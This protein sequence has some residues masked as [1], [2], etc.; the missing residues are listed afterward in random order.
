VLSIVTEVGECK[1]FYSSCFTLLSGDLV[2]LVL[3]FRSLILGDPKLL[4]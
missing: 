2:G 3:A 1:P 4:D